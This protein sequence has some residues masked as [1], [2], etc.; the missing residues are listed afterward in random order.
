MDIDAL[1]LLLSG[2]FVVIRVIRALAWLINLLKGA[3]VDAMPA[4]EI[5]DDDDDL[6]SRPRLDEI[7]IAS[8]VDKTATAGLNQPIDRRTMRKPD[9][10]PQATP[11]GPVADAAVQDMHASSASSTGRWDFGLAPVRRSP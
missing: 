1:L 10:P 11:S 8:C 4:A 2:G 7:A 6:H 5:D 9:A 3:L